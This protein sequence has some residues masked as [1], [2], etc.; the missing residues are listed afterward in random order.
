[1]NDSERSEAYELALE[2]YYERQQ[3][4]RD[5]W[6]YEQQLHDRPDGPWAELMRRV[7]RLVY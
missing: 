6:E 2:A 4:L 1:M 3:E 7:G 5:Q